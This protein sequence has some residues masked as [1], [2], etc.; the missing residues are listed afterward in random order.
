MRRRDQRLAMVCRRADFARPKYIKKRRQAQ[1]LPYPHRPWPVQPPHPSAASSPARCWRAWSA[2]PPHRR[3]EASA[4]PSAR[5]AAA[6]TRQSQEA[7]LRIPGSFVCSSSVAASGSANCAARL[8]QRR[9]SSSISF[10]SARVK[11]ASMAGAPASCAGSCDWRI[12]AATA[13]LRIAAPFSAFAAICCR[14]LP[15]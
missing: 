1:A 3:S 5:A 2:D 6:R 8:I 13:S 9:V 10:F 12:S 7:S 4:A 14:R 15:S 11:K